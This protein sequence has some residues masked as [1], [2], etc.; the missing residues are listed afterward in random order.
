MTPDKKQL[1]KLRGMAHSLKPVV[2]VGGKGLT[3]SVF[4]EID[5]ALDSHELIKIK[6]PA[7]PR[8][9]RESLV[10]DICQRS[11]SSFVGM[12]GRVAITFRKNPDKKNSISLDTTD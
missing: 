10:N 1:K 2:T 3:E 11:R 7:G 6:L 8:Q 5:S 12:T 4:A 9:V